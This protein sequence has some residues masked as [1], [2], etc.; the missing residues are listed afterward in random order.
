MLLIVVAGEEARYHMGHVKGQEE[1]MADPEQR[2]VLLFIHETRLERIQ[3]EE[4]EPTQ[5][6]HN[7]PGHIYDA[8]GMNDV[9][10]IV[11]DLS[12]PLHAYASFAAE[13]EHRLR[14]DVRH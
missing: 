4:A 9:S 1:G 3:R 2:E 7:L 5:R 8:V 13:Y 14:I 10:R 6:H 11:L 12:F